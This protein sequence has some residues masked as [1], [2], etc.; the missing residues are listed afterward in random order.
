MPDE[1]ACNKSGLSSGFLFLPTLRVLCVVGG[2]V[3]NRSQ[4]TPQRLLGTLAPPQV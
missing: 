2:L 3:R 4:V 1:D